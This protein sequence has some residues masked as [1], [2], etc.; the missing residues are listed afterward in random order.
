MNKNIS[1]K[2]IP[3]SIIISITTGCSGI[4]DDPVDIDIY[5]SEVKSLGIDEWVRENLYIR[6]EFSHFSPYLGSSDFK[7]RINDDY[8][9]ADW[10]FCE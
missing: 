8:V 5:P 6:Y 1:K 2:I 10:R 9:S 7:F 4:K 3:I